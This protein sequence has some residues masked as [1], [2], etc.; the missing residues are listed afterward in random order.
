[1]K[2]QAS[3]NVTRA[4]LE[5]LYDRVLV[6]GGERT[7]YEAIKK[8]GRYGRCPYCG[9]RDVKTLD[10]YLPKATFPEFAVLPANL[11]PCC[12]DCNHDK[13]EH[14]PSSYFDQLFHPY[15]DDWARFEVLKAD[16]RIGSTIDVTFRINSEALPQEVS[17]RASTQFMQLKLGSL[18]ANQASVEL[19]QRREVFQKTF[20]TGGRD[21]LEDELRREHQSRRKPFPNAW[22]P[23]LYLALAENEQFCSGG[24]ESIDEPQM[25][26]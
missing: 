21:A 16:I 18:Y 4:E 6:G 7:A 25:L 1:L 26:A 15:F 13:F 24:W 2:I 22:E 3:L 8:R 9:Q 11:I 14:S 10:H 23:V 12:S 17:K 5:N 20:A 19:V